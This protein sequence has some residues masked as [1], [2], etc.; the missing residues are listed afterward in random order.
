MSLIIILALIYA[1]LIFW[2]TAGLL[3]RS[4]VSDSEYRPRVSVIV[5]ARNEELNLELCL[6]S[7]S[8]QNY[9]EDLYDVYI[10]DDRSE[11]E[12]RKIGSRFADQQP[13][14]NLIV[15]DEVDLDISPKKN[16]IQKGI[17]AS[18]GE[19]IMTT[20]ADCSPPEGWISGIVSHYNDENIGMVVGYAPLYKTNKGLKESLLKLDALS[21]AAVA[22][23]SIGIG[24]PVTCTGRNFSYRRSVYESID[25]YEGL[26]HLM[27]GDDDLLLHKANKYGIKVSYSFLPSTFVESKTYDELS[28]IS[29]QRRRHAS[30]TPHYYSLTGMT[31]LKIALPLVY[32]L[33]LFIVSGLLGIGVS[34]PTLAVSLLLK[35]IA[36]FSLLYTFSSLSGDRNV[37]KYFPLALLIH[38]FYV[39][40]YGAWGTLGKFTWKG[41]T[42]NP[43]KI[44]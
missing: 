43:I 9:P 31:G 17:D 10:I 20:D 36:E 7:L 19:I 5:A 13:N 40:I 22:S 25:G 4:K 21:I 23:G 14:F 30:K 6:L 8:N 24:Y 2:L 28:E 41:Q 16:A 32:L 12:T 18:D 34:P 33:N 35:S 39:V 3:K 11:D 1:A 15:V 27:S 29:N 44:N 26:W 37:L 42:S 38:P